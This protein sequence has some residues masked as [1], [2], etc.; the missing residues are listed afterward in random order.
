VPDNTTAI[1]LS[2]DFVDI[3]AYGLRMFPLA[4][5]YSSHDREFEQLMQCDGHSKIKWIGR[6]VI[7]HAQT[8]T[9]QPTI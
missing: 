9:L 4:Q 2:S 1:T 8:S 7:D 6:A 3:V 5:A